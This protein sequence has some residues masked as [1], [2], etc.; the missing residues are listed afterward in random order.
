MPE[1]PYVAQPNDVCSVEWPDELGMDKHYC[2]KPIGHKDA[3]RCV[4]RES[5]RPARYDGEAT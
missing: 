5:W 4:C 3:H 2:D 1:N